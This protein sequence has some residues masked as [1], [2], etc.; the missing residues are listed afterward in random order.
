MT[1]DGGATYE[2]Y[3]YKPAEQFHMYSVD[4]DKDHIDFLVDNKVVRSVKSND[5]PQGR[6]MPQT[7]V[8][9][10]VGVWGGGDPD[11]GYW[12][13]QW[14]GGLIDFSKMPYSAIVQSV[15]IT[16]KNPGCFYQYNGN[17]SLPSGS[18]TE[19]MLISI[20]SLASR[21]VSRS[22]KRGVILPARPRT[23]PPAR[24]QSYWLPLQL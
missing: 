16:N 21:R 20:D 2:P 3:A 4:W 17:V 19:Y 11:G 22:S 18:I 9:L 13:Q 6:T 10:Q 7:P 15:N 12:V 5:L 24:P 8:K 1:W 14:A 23:W